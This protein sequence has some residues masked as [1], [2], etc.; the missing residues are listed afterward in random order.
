[1]NQ[2][3]DSVFLKLAHKECLDYPGMVIKTFM[4]LWDTHGFQMTF[5]HL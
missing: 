5:L 4:R 2:Q 1:M 3:L